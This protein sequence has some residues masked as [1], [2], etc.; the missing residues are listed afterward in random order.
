LMTE[1]SA[2]SAK[3]RGCEVNHTLQSTF[4]WVFRP[5]LIF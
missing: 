3:R 4:L 1:S 2:L 5:I